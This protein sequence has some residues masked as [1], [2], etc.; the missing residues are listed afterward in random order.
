MSSLF[1][2]AR[3]PRLRVTLPNHWHDLSQA[4]LNKPTYSRTGDPEGAL[5]EVSILRVWKGGKRPDASVENL[6]K[7]LQERFRAL[8]VKHLEGGELA[9]EPW[10]R[11]WATVLCDQPGCAHFQGWYLSDGQDFLMATYISGAT[12]SAQELEEARAIVFRLALTG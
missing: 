10:A 6:K 7:Q 3:N 9:H 11:S 1:R 5:L 8:S 12:P 2:K 4:N